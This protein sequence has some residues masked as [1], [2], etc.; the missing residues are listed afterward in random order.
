MSLNLMPGFFPDI[1]SPT[2][3]SIDVSE[4]SAEESF[5][6]GQ[7][8]EKKTAAQKHLLG[9][10]NA[11]SFCLIGYQF[12]K[13]THGSCLPP[14]MAHVF[15]QLLLSVYQV[16]SGNTEGSRR[17]LSEYLD[18][19]EE[20]L[21]LMGLT[22]DRNRVI[23]YMMSKIRSFIYWK[24][25]AAIVY[26][27]IFVLRWLWPLAREGRL[28][29]LENG[30]WNFLSFLGESLPQSYSEKDSW[31]TQLWT[32]GLFQ[33]VL[34]DL[35]CLIFQ[36][37]I[38]QCIFLQSTISPRGIR[39]GEPEVFIVR[40][41]SGGAVGKVAQDENGIPDVLH[42]KLYEALMGPMT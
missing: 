30:S 12:L 26:H 41:K 32:L 25:V 42:I 2:S 10:L 35:A 7:A 5:A 22:L 15:V 18:S 31:V 33:L 39:L 21:R 9:Q 1:T 20:L 16:N 14:T 36:L 37:T 6:E 17:I 19:Q 28:E 11:L 24:T 4:A 13:Y 8:V 23:G 27:L 34:L 38:F 40:G 29:L 3:S